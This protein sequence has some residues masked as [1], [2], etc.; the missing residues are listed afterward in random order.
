MKATPITSR[1]DH[2]DPFT[3]NHLF[4]GKFATYLREH[5]EVQPL[6]ARCSPLNGRESRRQPSVLSIVI[7]AVN[8][9]P[10]K[11]REK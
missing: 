9:I 1:I 10:V 3:T 4:L 6:T 7:R 2:P 11:E 8:Q 5:G